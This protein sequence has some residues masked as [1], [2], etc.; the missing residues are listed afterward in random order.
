LK[1][2]KTVAAAAD[3]LYQTRIDRLAAQHDIEPLVRFEKDLKEFLI[4]TLPKSD[5]NGAIGKFAKAQI[6]TK[7]IP[8][9]EDE[10]KFLA[11]ARKP[12]NEDL[13]KIVPNMEAIN[14]RWDDKKKVPGVVSFKVVTISS[15]KL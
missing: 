12:G 14:A 3:A 8:Q 7:D 1:L 2:P 13:L 6:K 11:F 9:I 15:T 10:K 4:N 5:A